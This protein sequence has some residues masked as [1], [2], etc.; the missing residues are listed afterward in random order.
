MC[1]YEDEYTYVYTCVLP[2]DYGIQTRRGLADTRKSPQEPQLLCVAW[3][4]LSEA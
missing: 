4:G 2:D 3:V 1:M